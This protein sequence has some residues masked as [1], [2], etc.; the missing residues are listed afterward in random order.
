MYVFKLD[1]ISA[2]IV[3]FLSSRDSP[4]IFNLFTLLRLAPVDSDTGKGNRTRLRAA[5]ANGIGPECKKKSIAHFYR[6]DF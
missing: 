5:F 2:L 1:C 3:Y 4:K 6:S